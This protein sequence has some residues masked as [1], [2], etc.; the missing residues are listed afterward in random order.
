MH[1]IHVRIK[2]R[3]DLSGIELEGSLQ[4]FPI[5]WKRRCQRHK[6]SSTSRKYLG[7]IRKFCDA[8]W[9]L[10]GF[11]LLIFIFL[12]VLFVFSFIC[13]FSLVGFFPVGEGYIP[14]VGLTDLSTICFTPPPPV[15]FSHQTIR[16]ETASEPGRFYFSLKQSI[17]FSWK[18][19]TACGQMKRNQDSRAAQADSIIIIRSKTVQEKTDFVVQLNFAMTSTALCLSKMF[20]CLCYFQHLH[21]WLF[22]EVSKITFQV[23]RAK[24]HTSFKTLCHWGNSASPALGSEIVF[25]HRSEE[26]DHG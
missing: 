25:W 26:W 24:S 21:N 11:C 9:G 10:M 13:F 22:V 3:D 12:V 4:F 7:Y 6:F 2:W 18:S 14:Y 1:T 16:N 17:I 15:M 5:I 19:S 20:Y 8:R 23:W